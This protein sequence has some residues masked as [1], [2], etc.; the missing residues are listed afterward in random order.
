MTL[1]AWEDQTKSKSVNLSLSYLHK[2][3]FCDYF[4]SHILH[5]TGL[6][7]TQWYTWVYMPSSNTF[8]RS[9]SQYL[10]TRAPLKCKFIN[11]LGDLWHFII[12]AQ[13]VLFAGVYLYILTWIALTRRA[14]LG[15][16]AKTLIWNI[17]KNKAFILTLL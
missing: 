8:V 1:S 4:P 14:R 5:K 9:Y 11:S 16:F 15:Y 12:S 10:N 3:L 17:C 6:E 7:W 2:L 13:K